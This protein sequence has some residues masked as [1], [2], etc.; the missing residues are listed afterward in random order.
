MP[1]LLSQRVEL[2]YPE[3]TRRDRELLRHLLSGLGAEDIAP[4]M[5]IQCSSAA[6]YIKRLYRKVGV[7]AHRELLGL[8]VRGRWS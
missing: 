5:G 7:S 4:L 8:V 3:L 1:S 6:T 2:L